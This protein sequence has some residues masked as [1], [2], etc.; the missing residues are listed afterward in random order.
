MLN[1]MNKMNIR[2]LLK[3]FSSRVMTVSIVSI[4]KCTLNSQ[5]VVILLLK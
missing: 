4:I 2:I 1:I 5:V 3:L